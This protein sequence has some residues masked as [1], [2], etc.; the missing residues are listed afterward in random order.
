MIF[1]EIEEREE[2]DI[3]VPPRGTAVGAWYVHTERHDDG[4]T[5]SLE[6]G[7]SFS[8]GY[9]NTLEIAVARAVANAA[10]YYP[11]S[12]PPSAATIIARLRR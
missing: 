2:E 7:S 5:V 6:K 3:I 1:N 4:Y 12:G 9:G 11:S 10:E 8:V